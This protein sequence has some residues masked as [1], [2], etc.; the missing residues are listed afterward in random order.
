[1][2]RL[3]TCDFLQQL[4][5]RVFLSQYDAWTALHTGAEPARR[6]IRTG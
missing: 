2:D 3:K 5:G 4:T 6:V 1:M